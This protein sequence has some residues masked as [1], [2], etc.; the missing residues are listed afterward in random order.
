[1]GGGVRMDT[2]VW[3]ELSPY[4]PLK[5]GWGPYVFVHLHIHSEVYIGISLNG[6]APEV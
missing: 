5:Y 1:M 3:I 6:K 2:E 4:G